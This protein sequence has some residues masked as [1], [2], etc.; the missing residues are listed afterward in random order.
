MAFIAS[1]LFYGFSVFVFDTFPWISLLMWAFQGLIVSL[2]AGFCAWPFSLSLVSLLRQYNSDSLAGMAFKFIHFSASL[3]LI[4]FICLFME[5]LGPDIFILVKDF[6]VETL[7]RENLL[8]RAIA[9]ILTIFF[10]PIS[11]LLSFSET[12]EPDVFF[13]EMLMG[14]IDFFQMALLAGVLI[15]IL[16]VFLIP[17]MTVTMHQSLMRNRDIS[18]FEVVQSL[19]GSHWE[20]VSISMLQFMKDHSKMILIRFVRICFFESLITFSVLKFFLSFKKELWGSTLSER[21]IFESLRMTEDNSPSLLVLAGC[22]AF[23]YLFILQIENYYSKPLLKN[24][25]EVF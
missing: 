17:K 3:P 19:G 11:Q 15:F 8:T 18:G 23:I 13:N 24:K 1:Y 10:F 22:L 25:M 20:S 14:V 9:F 7:V 5:V 2:M 4:L 16:T 21:F 12:R 6:L